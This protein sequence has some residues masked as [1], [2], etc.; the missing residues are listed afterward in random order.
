MKCRLLWCQLRPTVFS[1]QYASKHLVII[2]CS[3]V[4]LLVPF[5]SVFQPTP[6]HAQSFNQQINYQG[7]LA[8]NLGA[9]V[10]DGSYSM[11]FRLYTVATAGTHVWTET[12]DVTVTNGLFSIMLGSDTSLS[13]VDFNQ[14]LYLGVKIET[15][16]EMTPPARYSAQSQPPLRPTTHRLLVVSLVPASYVTTSPTPLQPSYPSPAALS[17]VRRAPLASSPPVPPPSPP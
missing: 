8:D 5:F 3:L 17:V 6:A 7:K 16:D 1:M 9:T 4:L 13:G 15:D 11:V 14:T 12:Q 2:I 10:A